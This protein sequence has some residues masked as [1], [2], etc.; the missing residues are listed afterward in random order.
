MAVTVSADTLDSEYSE[1]LDDEPFSLKDASAEV[2]WEDPDNGK[3]FTL[4]DWTSP[5]A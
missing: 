4:A 1:T 5:T 2:V 3:S